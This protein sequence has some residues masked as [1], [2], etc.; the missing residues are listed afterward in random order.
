MAETK[1]YLDQEGVAHLWS[2]IN[3]QDYPNNEL[4]IGV[5]EAIDETK[6][7]KEN[8]AFIDQEDNE[9]VEGV[10]DELISNAELNALLAALEE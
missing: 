10:E 6:A 7:N 8:V 4:L 1:K 2:K 3:M 5:I 9:N